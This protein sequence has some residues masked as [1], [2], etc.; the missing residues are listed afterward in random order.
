MGFPE[1]CGNARRINSKS[2]AKWF[3]YQSVA[4]RCHLNEKARWRNQAL[5]RFDRWPMSAKALLRQ[6][7]DCD[8]WSDGFSSVCK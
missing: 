6:L 7:R 8:T 1:E 2:S 3:T 4:L 5:T